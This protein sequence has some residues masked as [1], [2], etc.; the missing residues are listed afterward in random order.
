VK[1]RIPV[2]LLITLILSLALTGCGSGA[3]A[4]VGESR[5]KTILQEDSR[6][7]ADF[8]SKMDAVVSGNPDIAGRAKKADALAANYQVFWPGVLQGKV[9]AAEWKKVAAQQ[10]D[11]G[12]EIYGTLYGLFARDSVALDGKVSKVEGIS[13]NLSTAASKLYVACDNLYSLKGLDDLLALHTTGDGTK[14]KPD[15]PPPKSAVELGALGGVYIGLDWDPSTGEL[16]LTK[17]VGDPQYTPTGVAVTAAQM[18]NYFLGEARQ[19][20]DEARRAIAGEQGASS[21]TAPGI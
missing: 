14:V 16:K 3:G 7:V 11:L 8:I 18:E 5:A 21:A 1:A 12:T 4:P 13:G 17:Y 20:L 2:A 19:R 6:E 15:N 10:K 9:S